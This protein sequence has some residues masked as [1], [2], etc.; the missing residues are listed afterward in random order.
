M[1]AM[2]KTY[3][4]EGQA[5]ELDRLQLQSRVWE[6]SGRRLLEE[7]GEGRR[8]RVLDVGCGALGWLRVLSDWVGPDGQVVGTDIDEKMLA[9]ADQLTTADGLRSVSLMKDDLFATDLEPD[10]FDLVH[11]RFLSP[12]GRA[13]EQMDAYVRLARP[14]GTIVIEDVDP[15]SWHFVPSAPAL[16]ELISLI[17]RAF[18]QR[19]LFNPPEVQM[20]MFR[21]AGIEVQART[22][23]IALPPGHPYQRLPLQF[24]AGLHAPLEAFVGS[25]KLERLET[26]AERELQ[27]PN[28]WGVTFTLFQAWG[29]V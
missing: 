25:E 8:K 13:T 5:S 3:F 2:A 27:D 22:E 15:N 23:V 9:A 11:A 7:I 28:R 6:D 1:R 14:G 18:G 29:R 17:R 10:S 12:V 4:L 16:E 21:N 20:E 26:E 19:G 24:A